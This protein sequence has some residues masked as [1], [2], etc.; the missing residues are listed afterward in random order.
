MSYKPSMF[1]NGSC[2][3]WT[4]NYND[5]GKC[6]KCGSY[7]LSCGDGNSQPDIDFEGKIEEQVNSQLQE[8]VKKGI[9]GNDT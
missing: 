6:N 3:K 7:V 1:C 5:C 2:M 8:I 9:N 4:K